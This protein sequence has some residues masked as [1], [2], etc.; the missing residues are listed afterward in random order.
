MAPEM[1]EAEMKTR[2]HGE[3]SNPLRSFLDKQFFEKNI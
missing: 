3:F 2:N 1:A